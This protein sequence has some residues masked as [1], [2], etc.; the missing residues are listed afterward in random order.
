MKSSFLSGLFGE[1]QAARYLKKQGMR[2]LD[3]RYRTAHG[4]IDLIARDG[5]TL[6]F[7]EV[8]NRPR[9]T[10]GEGAA[11]VNRDKKRHLRYAAKAYLSEN[12]CERVR[13]DVVEITAA[14]IRHIPGAL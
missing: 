11:A 7:V 13:F 5:D 14:G 3:R 2:I 1:G 4:E 6:V 10:I 9:G 12:P 8:K